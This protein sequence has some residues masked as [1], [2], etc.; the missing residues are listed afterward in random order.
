MSKVS[1]IIKISNVKLKP[2]SLS[3]RPPGSDQYRSCRPQ[4]C[5]FKLD[6]QLKEI[7]NSRFYLTTLM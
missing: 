5:G 2:S 6:L 7:R 1:N 3:P 4:S